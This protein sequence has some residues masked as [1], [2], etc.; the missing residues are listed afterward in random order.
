MGGPVFEC[1]IYEIRCPCCPGGVRTWMGRLAALIR[2]EIPS[3]FISHGKTRDELHGESEAPA[4]D[5]DNSGNLKFEVSFDRRCLKWCLI[6][7]AAM[8]VLLGVAF[9]FFAFWTGL[10][11][12]R[13]ETVTTT[14]LTYL[15]VDSYS[16]LEDLSA[17]SDVIVLGV[18]RERAAWGIGARAITHQFRDNVPWVVHEL[19]VHEVFRG[20]V[21]GTI[22]VSTTDPVYFDGWSKMNHPPVTQLQPGDVVILYLTPVPHPGIQPADDEETDES[23][24]AYEP[25]SYDNGVFNVL[26]DV[27]AVTDASEV[28]PRGIHPGMFTAGT[29]FTLAEVRRAAEPNASADP[30]VATSTTAGSVKPVQTP[31]PADGTWF[32]DSVDGRPLI[33]E[34][35]ITMRI[36]GN[37]LEGFDGCNRYGGVLE[38]ETPV[39]DAAGVFSLPPLLRTEKGCFLIDHANPNAIMDQA[40]EYISAL[41]RGERYRVADGRLE[42]LDG[43]GVTRLVFLREAPPPRQSAD[44]RGTSWRLI[45]DD[46]DNDEGMTTLTFNGRLA[47]G[48]TACRDY[49]AW[50]SFEQSEGSVDFTRTSMLGSADSCSESARRRE[51]EFRS[52]LSQAWEYSVS[53]EEG[54]TRLRITNSRGKTLTFEPLP[55]GVEVID[56]VDGE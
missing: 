27:S 49:L 7:G 46:A 50:Y 56:I 41:Q 8:A 31:S 6:A 52:F 22:R 54:T 45:T 5:Q 15:E 48:S 9:V 19:E 14:E 44:L 25:V 24:V 55:P 26:D 11:G 42:I 37:E 12:G 51:G 33:E 36:T 39:A 1:G 43:E 28:L 10:W 53:E 18:V 38:D 17:A 4:M 29:V 3:G 30:I 40:D 35:E 34:R 32:L 20:E 16:T 2:P 47:I 21:G 13:T 23:Y